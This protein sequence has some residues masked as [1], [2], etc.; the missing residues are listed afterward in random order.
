M[1]VVP[2]YAFLTTCVDPSQTSRTIAAN[3]IVNS[4]ARVVGSLIAT[5]LSLAGVAIVN[6]L[7]LSAVM[8]LYS[9]QLARQLVAAERR[10]DPA[11][12]PLD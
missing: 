7:L 11:E 2:L 1:F 10:G 12:N 4:A 5:G 3:N 6:Q 9:A 8:C